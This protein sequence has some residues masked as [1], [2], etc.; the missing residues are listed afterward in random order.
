MSKKHSPTPQRI[1]QFAWGYAPTLVIEACV[2]HGIFDLLDRGPL[3]AEQLTSQ[4]GTSKRGV[5][6]L[7]DV[8]VSL[9]L[10]K[11]KGDRFGLTAESAAFL[12]STK[13]S[14]YGTFFRHISDQLLPK[15]LQLTK[16]V[17]TG[18]PA[19][20][21]NARKQGA[22]FFA[23]FVESLFP[24]SFAAAS[25]LG[26]HLAMARTSV[27]I[28]VLDIGA[29]SGVWGIA[30]AKQSPLVRIHAVDWPQVLKVTQRMAR[31]HGLAKR[32]SSAAGD[33]FEAD[34]GKGHQVATI[35]HI[36]HSEGRERSRR[37]LKK[38]FNALAP[39]GKVAIQEFLPNDERT[40][41]PVALIFAV[42]MLV[43]TEAGDT[44]TFAEISQWLREAGFKNP[45][46]LEVPSVSPLVLADKPK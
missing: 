29:G 38:T 22:E 40:G 30:L 14:Y 34:F 10:A 32:Y 37:L 39:G 4:T 5:K 43:N 46:L 35:G 23:E 18:R 31:K 17:R 20:R 7:L 28:S 24:V 13:P 45:R 36:L 8:L 44:F 12:V 42:N 6:A 19:L 1:M 33:F 21:V 9:D 27:P 2:R 41:P 16:I 26:Q 11:R 15:W 3:T 25:A